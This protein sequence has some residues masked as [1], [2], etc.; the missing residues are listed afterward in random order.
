MAPASLHNSHEA[1]RGGPGAMPGTP[2]TR[3][4]LM[5]P[6]PIRPAPSSYRHSGH[7]MPKAQTMLVDDQVS[8]LPVPSIPQQP[9][10]PP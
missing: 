5:T 8:P 2:D 3:A 1:A 9:T 6:V 10:T 7:S 4:R